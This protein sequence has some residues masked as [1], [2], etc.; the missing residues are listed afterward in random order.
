MSS[1]T[2]ICYPYSIICMILYDMTEKQRSEVIPVARMTLYSNYYS[3]Q[4]PLC[5]QFKDSL[6]PNTSIPTSMGMEQGPL[7]PGFNLI[8]VPL[9]SLYRVAG[10]AGGMNYS[11]LADL[12]YQTLQTYIQCCLTIIR[13]GS[14][15]TCCASN[16]TS[17][18]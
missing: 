10:V 1:S 4:Y 9:S 13:V 17:V 3:I 7:A 14:Q 11:L 2:R 15:A 6:V 5:S 12:P 16:F 18:P 8:I